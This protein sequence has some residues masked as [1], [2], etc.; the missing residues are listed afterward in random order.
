MFDWW[1]L[2]AGP[3]RPTRRTPRGGPKLALFPHRHLHA[4]DSRIDTCTRATDAASPSTN[5]LGE[6]HRSEA[7]ELLLR[8]KFGPRATCPAAF[9]YVNR[10][11]LPPRSGIGRLRVSLG[12]LP[13]LRCARPRPFPICTHM[14]PPLNPRLPRHR[15]IVRL[16]LRVY[17]GMQRSPL[18]ARRYRLTP[19]CELVR[20][21]DL[22]L[23]GSGNCLTEAGPPLKSR[24]YASKRSR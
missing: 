20:G 8:G 5:A 13:T 2:P 4:A 24:P 7:R 12:R 3:T 6:S 9:H 22:N 19:A 10:V 11:V 14:L 21:R 1:E 23:P 16:V 17:A 18:C 15:W